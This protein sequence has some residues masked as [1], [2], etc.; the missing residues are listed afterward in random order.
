MDEKLTKALI[1]LRTTQLELE[2]LKNQINE[3]IAIIGMSCRFPGGANN[4]QAFWDLLKNGRDGVTEIPPDRWDIDSFYDPNLDTPGK[5][6][7]RR[8]GFLDIDIDTFDANFFSISAREAEYMDP[9]HRLLLEVA[10]E[11]LENA[12][13]NPLSLKNS[14]TGVFLGICSHD[15]NDLLFQL[16]RTEDVN[17]YQTT[18]N[19]SSILAGRLSY[20]LGLQG[21]SVAID[22]AC[23]SS[24]VSI[25]YACKSL[26]SEECQL[27]L[28]GGVNLILNPTP[29]ISFCNG[30]M[31][32][33]D[34][35][36]KTFDEEADGYIRSEGCG[37]IVLKRLSEALKEQ[38]PILGIIRATEVNQDG[39]TSGLTVPNSEAQA[40]LI[41]KA[42]ELAALEPNAI[43][44][45]EAHG[46]GTPLGDPIE[47]GALSNVFSGRQ[48][49]DHPLWLGSVK[50][51]IGHLEAA[52]GVAGV[53][54]TVLALN[55]DA[56]P[57]HLH[58]KHLNPHI[59]LDSIPAKI[60][61]TLTP[62]HRTSRPRIA[63]ISS[64]GFSGTNSHAIIEEPPI[65]EIKKNLVDR[66][67]HLLTL[68]AKTQPALDQLV[69]LYIKHLPKE[70][71]ADIAFTSNTGRA[72]FSH[73]IIIVAQTKDEV[74]M[75]LQKRNFLIGKTP[76]SPP[77]V[78]FIFTGQSVENTELMETSP[79]FKEAME[80]S[81]GLYEYALFE[82]WKSWGI[83][84]DYVAGEGVGDITAAIIAGIFTLEEGLRL[85]AVQNNPN[86]L[87]SV[88]REI[89]YHEPQIGFISSWTGQIVRKEGMTADY[90][91]PHENIRTI[92][93][94]TLIISSQSN[95]KDI[96]QTLSQLYLNGIQIDW[97]A[98][99]KPYNRKKVSLPNYP[100]Q[101][102]KYWVD[103]LKK[104]KKRILPPE[105]HPLF[106]EL[107]HSPSKEK[108][109]KNEIDLDSLAYLKDHKVFES[110]LFPAA[111]FAELM[112]AVGSK[113][114]QGQLF[115]INNLIIE[116][117]LALD[118]KKAVPIELLAIPNEGGYSA[119]VYSIAEQTWILHAKCDLSASKSIPTLQLEWEHLRCACQK[120][121]DINTLYHQFDA[122]GLHY[123]KQFRTLRK[124]WTDHNEFIA[125]LEGE[126]STALI[127]GGFQALA[128]LMNEG[129]GAYLP[130]SMD[131]ICCYSKIGTSIRIQGKVTQV[132]E[133]STTAQI[134]I[135]SNDGK[136][137]M[138]IEGFHARKTDQAHLQQMLVKKQTGVEAASWFYQTSWLPK[139]LEKIGEPLKGHWLIVSQD[140]KGVEG[141]QYKIVKPEQAVTEIEAN[142]PG[143]VLWFATGEDS[144][145]HALEFVQA[146]VKLET[147]P[148]LYFIT[149]GI[150]P[151][152]P[153]TNL[154]ITPFNGFY[155]TL[156]LE[157]PALDCRHIDLGPN[158][159]LPQE[160]LLAAD[161]EG[162]VAYNLGIRYVPRLLSAVN[163]KRSG[164][165]LI[166]PM[167]ECFQLETSPTGSF[168]N[169]YLRPKNEIPTI[170]PREIA[171]E[172]KAASL[173]FRDVLI[174]MGFQV[175]QPG[176][177]GGECSGTVT[178]IGHE[179]TEFKQG[180]RV[181]GFGFFASPITVPAE[182]F[183]L[184]PPK[185]NFT[186]AAAI[187]I[188]F[189]TAYE[190]LIHLAKIKPGDKIL[191]H[192][193]AGGVG[194]AAIQIAQQA[195]AD[196]YATASSQAKHA[197]LRS[198]GIKHIYNSRTLDYAEEILR[199]TQGQ[200]V[201]I[202][203]NSLS[204]EGFIEKTVSI[205][206]QGARFVE[207]GKRKIWSKES[208][209]AVRPDIDY[210]ILAI[211]DMLV[212]QPQEVQKLLQT[213]M[214]HFTEGKFKALPSTCFPITDAESAF[215]YLQRAKNIGKVVLTFPESRKLKIDPAGSY[216]ITGGMGG[217]G[218]KVAEWLVTQG[219]KH[220]ILA[221]RR[222]SPKIEIPNA[223]VET[224]SIDIA[225]KPAVDAL[226][227]K[228]GSEWPELKGIIHAAGV[229]D[230]GLLASQDWNKFEKVFAPKVQGSWNLH[231]ASLTKPLDFLVLF[232]SVAS[233]I[234]SPGQIN[235]A[236]ANAYMEAI[237]QFR[238]DKGLPA[239][240]ISWG[241]WTEVGLAAGLTERHRASGFTAFKPN[242]GIKAFE[243]ALREITS[244]HVTVANVDWKLV[245]YK[246]TYLSE[247]IGAKS[248]EEPILLQGLTNT[249]PS[250]RKNF[251]I[252]Y[253]QRVVGKILGL[254]SINPEIGFFE[255]G[256]DSLMTEELQEKL[257]ADIGNLHKFPSTL[258]FD[259][260]NVKKLSEYF[261]KNI[262][263]LI[264][265]KAT[266]PKAAPTK[267]TLETDRIAII[268]LGCRF[269]GG[270][271][272]PQAFWEL[273]KQG[274]DGTT[275]VPKDRWDI[276]SFY[277]PDPEAPGKM[278][279][280]R[281][282]FLSMD[283]DTFDAN[284][285]GISP[286]E[287][288]YMDPQQRLL[289]EVAWE[290]LE[291]ACINPF[292]LNGSQ[293]G[294]FLGI[295]SHD[296]NDLLSELGQR[297][298]IGV[299]LTTGNASSILAGRLSYFLGLQGP[300]IALD[301]ACSSSLVAI[302]SACNSLQSGKCQLAL[303]GGVNLILNPSI[304]I[305]MC[306]GHM[307]AKDG[308]CKTFDAEADG[309]VRGE[310]CGVIVLKLLSDAIR[311]QDPILGVIRATEINQDGAS[312]G[313][314]V[315]N[316][317]AQASLIRKVLEQAKLEPNAIDYIETHG[318]GTSLG[319]PIE[320]GAI[321]NI[322]SGRQD[323]PL[324]LGAVK[325]N[326]GHLEA[327]AGIAGVIKTVLAL[328]HE[329]IPPHLHF[330]QL[331]PRISID[332][333]P[334]LIPLTLTPWQRSSR[335]RISGVS[336]FGFSGTNAHAIIEE[337]PL[338][339]LQKNLIDR[340]YHL[341]TLSAKTQTALDQL[342]DLY[343]KQLP[344]ENI[345][346]I[347]FTA[348]SG[349]AHFLH[350]VTIV[351]QTRDELLKHLQTW[352]YWI[353]D[354][355][356]PPAKVTFIFTGQLIEDTEL[357]ETS[358]VFKE[359]IER[360][361]G[362]YEYALFELWKSWGIAP[363][364]VLGEGIGD[365]IAAI[366]AQIIT[367]EEGLRII[368]AR[369]NNPTELDQVSEEIHY[370]EP[371]LGFISS[372]TG[373]VIRKESLTVDYWK[374]HENV[375]NIP[376]GTLVISN[377]HHW[378]DLLQTL[379]Q[380][381]LNGIQIDWKAF[382][383]PYNRKK[384]YLPTYP[385]QRER[386]WV[387]A[388]KRQKKR[389]I[390]PQA[391]PLL[392]EY[393]ASPSKEKLF[394]NEID[395]DYLSFLK[396]HKVFDSILFPGAGFTE[397]LH[398][399][400]TKL[401]QSQSFTINS[402]VIEQPLTLEIKKATPIELLATPQEE[403][404]IAS[405]YSIE[406]EVWILHAKGELSMTG[407]VPPPK[408]EWEHLRSVCESA[409][410][411]EDLY[412]QFDALGIH[413]GKQF[414]T[415]Q[416]L[417]TGN[418]EFIAEL[419][420][421]ASSALIDGSM[422]ALAALAIKKGTQDSVYLPYS[423]NKI[424]VYSEIGT[425]IRIHGKLTQVTEDSTT[426]E[427]EIFSYDSK[428]LM[429]IEGFHLRKTD[430]AHLRQMLTKQ[431]ELETAPWFYQIS[432]LP[433]SL[434]KTE[435]QLKSPWLIVAQ[436]EERIEGLQAKTIKPEHAIKEIVKNPP[437]GV[438]WFA[439][440]KASLRY[441]LE[442]V[443]ALDKLETKLNLYLI[444]HG[445][446]PIRPITDL[447]NATFNGF[448]RTLKLEIPTLDCRHID[449]GLNEKLPVEELL[450]PDQEEQVAYDQGVRYVPR[451][452]Y[453]SKVKR[454][455]KKLMNPMDSTGSYLITGGLGGLGL[456]VAEWLSQQG[457]KHLVLAG[458]RV[459]QNIEIPNT[460]VETVAIDVS[461]KPDVDALMKK[462]GADWPELKGIIHAAGVL[463]DGILPS[464]DWSRF[465]KV[466]APKVEGS[467]NLHEASL[468]KPLDFFV[469]FSSIA[470]T[471]GSPGQINYASANA[472]MDA[473]ATFRHDQGLPALTINWGP[474]AEV[475]LAASFTQRYRASGFIAFKPDE[476]IKAFELALT[477]TSI[478]QISIANVNW[479][480]VPFKQ[481][482]LSDLIVSKTAEKPILL[483]R[484]TDVLPSERK[485]LLTHY[486]QQTVG[487]ILGLPSINPE[488][489]FFEAGMDSL[490][491]AEFRIRLQTDLGSIA[492]IPPTL[493]FD[494]PSIQKL[495]QY[496]EEHIFPFIG[497]TEIVPKSAP[498][499]GVQ[500]N[501]LKGITTYPLNEKKQEFIW[502]QLH[503]Q[504]WKHF[505]YKL[506]ETWFFKDV[507]PN[508]G[509]RIRW[510]ICLDPSLLEKAINDYIKVNPIFFLK[511]ARFS[512]RYK[513]H[514]FV[515]I[516]ISLVDLRKKEQ[517]DKF[518]EKEF[519]LFIKQKFNFYRPPFFSAIFY[520]LSENCFELFYCFPHLI[521]DADSIQIA[522]KAI[523]DNYK[524]LTNGN[525]SKSYQYSKDY[526][527]YCEEFD[528][529]VEDLWKKEE[530]NWDQQIN[531]VDGW[532]IK[533]K[534]KKDYPSC[535]HLVLQKELMS[536]FAQFCKQIN[537]LESLSLN[538]IASLS[539]SLQL[540]PYKFCVMRTL[541]CRT[542]KVL[543]DVLGPIYGRNKIIIDYTNETK[544]LDYINLFN[545]KDT[546][547]ISLIP[548][549]FIY[550]IFNSR[551]ESWSKWDFLLRWIVKKYL[552]LIMPKNHQKYFLNRL[553]TF[554]VNYKIEN[555]KDQS[556]MKN[557]PLSFNDYRI[558]SSVIIKS[559]ELSFEIP[560]FEA[561]NLQDIMWINLLKL[562]DDN[563]DLFMYSPL[564]ESMELKI[565][566]NTKTI[567]EIIL[568]NPNITIGE[569][570]KLLPLEE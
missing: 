463:D 116:Q 537:T 1:K 469:L 543:K 294:V 60:P 527:N 198:L 152:R 475:G 466:F 354:A 81:K 103:A 241:P 255:A 176:P 508:C 51:N 155:R 427:I 135:F 246:Q 166:T 550:N 150:Q 459:S 340:P 348:N 376:E 163:A 418:N 14:P 240:A 214:A 387:E 117:P 102:E 314:T 484:L 89:Q 243:S 520:Q 422:Q 323:R 237:A 277:D 414:Q 525:Q 137:L 132:T 65:I 223:T 507:L 274:Y 76:A 78:V 460:T 86:E 350:R 410:D 331:N 305:S 498:T 199:D 6:Y 123:G 439:S 453:S 92:V 25:H 215:E 141:I 56:I 556:K 43:D 347:V 322:F 219:A 10:W 390:P 202:V 349:R 564:I 291:Q 346:D 332:S 194:L 494:Y 221:G 306:K 355:S 567:I 220:L 192:A 416:K 217:L 457:A 448:Y 570:R 315:P 512:L 282:G 423:I 168:E 521:S 190:A 216:L 534:Y 99:D 413:Y 213:I 479:K 177:L 272:N 244:P 524:L 233:S 379:A 128:A 485:D 530:G 115:T 212:H 287:A 357:M 80:R 9:Q 378:K 308:H 106:G 399:A 125:E 428:P 130:Y 47:V 226:M 104:H 298:E 97:K 401:F 455:T 260:P 180:D 384:V 362:L 465:E 536:R 406:E 2:D 295:C 482:L 489:G 159:K 156:R 344:D 440:G 381:Y 101:R 3:P 33:K 318:T 391:H 239:L 109:F 195:G 363:D 38:D 61:L 77:N 105:D 309:Y 87:E 542:S 266:T 419:E 49:Q 8:G 371:Q 225:Q 108:L 276:D 186:E 444:T 462:F 142:S 280:R 535:T 431:A 229:L 493:I 193:A 297:D 558:F 330:K 544:L 285:F 300:C 271:N 411:I 548:I 58:F 325:T 555:R 338:I 546:K 478:P 505:S 486:L 121:I 136:P 284:F 458:R 522:F 22:T 523:F 158:E 326:I 235:Y 153:I 393:I 497:I 292:S 304:V 196:I 207:I 409:I 491:S 227:Q 131:Q 253:L 503:E 303:A 286:R 502:L 380:L 98:Y 514:P 23:S 554:L 269:P 178:R 481:S 133:D 27:A 319:D 320:I 359:A 438:L 389:I 37:V 18:G 516:H 499:T 230:D 557:I 395:L 377:Q 461:Q 66:P 324:L 532:Y 165:K 476:G 432:W 501:H 451:L 559:T 83:T 151:V 79:V 170:G 356:T 374:P 353:G 36:C 95:W 449:L 93:E 397:L 370:R 145:K 301:T 386:Y 247:L 540:N 446:Q 408:M 561:R 175:G 313:L 553:A 232:S 139:P 249:L 334:A 4:P 434:A 477:E 541:D 59:S 19:T 161:L 279:V 13:I 50:T 118:N 375:K 369:S 82:L 63:G 471:I 71:L 290:A 149:H 302:H 452:Q 311:D 55:H 204:G 480:L 17:V 468:T 126:D 533:G 339:E 242:E 341:L 504:K 167:A 490:M 248:A 67:Y 509:Y 417:W 34:G 488:I 42:L 415:L 430:Q 11:A 531:E 351:A 24:I 68:S 72:H 172:V 21:P 110:V 134:G 259:Y 400:G 473:L 185:L 40:G 85:L 392:G 218:L 41:C 164:K 307:L 420:G 403:G 26:Q 148:S 366:A 70:D 342:V 288:D 299:Y 273:L 517:Q 20:F 201:D 565:M 335:P 138:K 358:P 506:E 437:T 250:E 53:I 367:L 54:K 394:R 404:Y 231:E 388:L 75:N 224:V 140:E 124:L 424:N 197:Y 146:L 310:G 88:A 15:Y 69:E 154:E 94:D 441:A 275:E 343:T 447:E 518:L 513:I 222:N 450:A 483:Q 492:T 5:M 245:S 472:Y 436:E 474:W 551:T 296:Y 549:Q 433:K 228:F 402:L 368:T 267:A 412:N 425:S 16:E 234:G 12:C 443:Q 119:S 147:R 405:V 209:Q 496:F 263:S 254:S 45:I 206:H 510:N 365:I 352:D 257:Q 169:L 46:T 372:W 183:T 162:Q 519:A 500:D 396:D 184:I 252:N 64:F 383:K 210:F 470:S 407:P 467:W 129:A 563:V 333:I 48:G 345:A 360:S 28:A 538:A 281:S 270:A 487:K 545:V 528:K 560:K 547:N 179:V 188:V 189:S 327:A 421:E 143:G 515:P 7:V 258:A 568:N 262:F 283:I 526:L 32:A 31:L 84:P 495:S 52:A 203:L 329:A 74:L 382:D 100:F 454:S 35:N 511:F 91:K 127:D 111:G 181:V 44:Y 268:G 289:L 236:S 157:M 566:E 174:A 62:W 385:F 39:A 261:E 312:S 120:S 256:M 293:T 265:I 30:R 435:E 187:P 464:Q 429:K 278:Y 182:F 112:H 171:V 107:I 173:N 336:S 364:Y 191:I 90:W 211:D 264:G 316:G 96:L 113:L 122:L 552:G 426:G 144:L 200:G 160:E 442:F 238:H 337:P 445:I 29:M 456:K 539:C 373:Q 114:F 57:P 317:E 562:P 529:I 208:M 398:A 569:L 251:L 205:C 321:S 73:R 361:H 328:N